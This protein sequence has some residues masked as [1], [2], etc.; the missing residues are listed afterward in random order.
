MLAGC[1]VVWP[2]I[3]NPARSTI[4][5]GATGHVFVVVLAGYPAAMI[6]PYWRADP[7]H[8]MLLARDPLQGIDVA[9]QAT[10]ALR[11]RNPDPE[12]YRIGEALADSVMRGMLSAAGRSL[13]SNRP[14]SD[15]KPDPRC[16]HLSFSTDTL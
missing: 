15:A 9:S 14:G 12:L 8:K 1:L 5:C 6:S 13:Y 7:I 2:T 3:G 4:R 10:F 16:Q 11:E